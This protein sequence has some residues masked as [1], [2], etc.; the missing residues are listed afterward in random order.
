[1]NTPTPVHWTPD[2]AA[3]FTN[4]PTPIPIVPVRSKGR[5]MHGQLAPYWGPIPRGRGGFHMA[6]TLPARIEVFNK[7]VARY[8]EPW[9]IGIAHPPAL[10]VLDCDVP[11]QPAERTGYDII[12]SRL[13]PADR[14]LLDSLPHAQTS[15]GGYHFFAEAPDEW[16]SRNFPFLHVD[17]KVG[18][19]SYVRAYDD[20]L[21]AVRQALA[22]T[23]LPQFPLPVIAACT[24]H[25]VYSRPTPVVEPA[26]RARIISRAC[27]RI[28][29]QTKVRNNTLYKESRILWFKYGIH[30][31]VLRN[32]AISQG[33]T[34]TAVDAT[35]QSAMVVRN[36]KPG[37]Q[38][39]QRKETANV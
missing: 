30:P 6:T 33:Q 27:S 39:V 29:H 31:S 23:P 35:I 38:Q 22:S 10:A 21:D 9:F 2:A 25:R 37:Q 26:Y 14:A 13:T 11:D 17:T 32:A 34:P 28:A 18:G 19:T 1:M 3:E 20:S 15:S 16:V 36:N 24:H 7:E 12:T 4:S 8:S 5:F